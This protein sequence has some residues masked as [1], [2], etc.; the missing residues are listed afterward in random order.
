[1]PWLKL[2][3][4]AGQFDPE[5]LSQFFE[6]QGAL[7]VTFQ[8]AADHPLYE[9]KPGETP[10]WLA[11]NIIALFDD[12]LDTNYLRQQFINTFGETGA[13]RIKI[14]TLPDR[15]WER[16][17]LDDFKPMQFG[18]RLWVCPAGMR[19]EQSGA[20]IIDLDPGL[21]FGTGTHPT[22]ALCLTWLDQNPPANLEVLDYGCG[23]GVLGMA[24]LKLGA[25]N[26]CAVDIDPQALWATRNNAARNKLDSQIKTTLPSDLPASYQADLVL[27]NI[28]ANPLIEMADTLAGFIKP[29]G[30][31]VLSGILDGQ[32]EQVMAA[33][34]GCLQMNPPVELEGWV[35]L[36]GVKG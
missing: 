23:S 36:T 26:V 19:P 5:I 30:T 3:I 31:L 32:A 29:G 20:V 21:A 27:A 12:G 1:M 13:E 10:L 33:Y 7:S 35:C 28:L 6:A 2:S 16:A 9:P 14:E 22:T 4:E 11:T 24:T 25:A 15:D 18:R 34:S 17:W 8:D